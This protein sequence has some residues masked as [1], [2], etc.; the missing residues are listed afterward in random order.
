M[1]SLRL[2]ENVGSFTM[3]TIPTWRSIPYTTERQGGTN[4]RDSHIVYAV[5]ESDRTSCNC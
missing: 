3:A 4:W 5:S 1:N 2:G